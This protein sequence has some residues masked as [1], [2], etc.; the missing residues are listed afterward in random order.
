MP[1]SIITLPEDLANIETSVLVTPGIYDYEVDKCE[2]RVGG[3]GEFVNVTARILDGEFNGQP[4]FIVLS[5][6]K[7]ALWKLKQFLL[8]LGAKDPRGKKLDLNNLLRKK[9]SGELIND[10][11]DPGD[12]T[13]KRTVN[14]INTFLTFKA[15]TSGTSPATGKVAEKEKEEDAEVVF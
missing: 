11:Y 8:A 5:T 13:G 14:R 2:I 9:F 4:V 10:E 12:G 1:S 15:A 3:K 7:A 6:S